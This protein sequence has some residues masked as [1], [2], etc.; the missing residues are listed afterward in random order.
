MII[1]YNYLATFKIS[2]SHAPFIDLLLLQSGNYNNK[3]YE[4]NF[5]DSK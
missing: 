1:I 3:V 5:M 2:Q 4:Y